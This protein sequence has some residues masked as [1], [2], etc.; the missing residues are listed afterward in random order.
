LGAMTDGAPELTLTRRGAVVTGRREKVDRDAAF[1]LAGRSGRP[2][3]ARGA[4]DQLIRA[5]SGA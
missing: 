3:S 1:A 2:R 5:S 4:T